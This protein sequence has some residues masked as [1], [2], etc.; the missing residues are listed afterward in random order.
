[1]AQVSGQTLPLGAGVAFQSFG[2]LA[3]GAE[4]GPRFN[5]GETAQAGKN[6]S[7]VKHNNHE[8]SFSANATA[9]TPSWWRLG[10]GH[11]RSRS[12]SGTPPS[13]ACYREG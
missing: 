7:A 8:L 6:D 4:T 10:F 2:I 5:L 12:M 1:M 11:R 3:P 9:T 13:A